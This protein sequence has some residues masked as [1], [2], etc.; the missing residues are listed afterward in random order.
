MLQ[1][2]KLLWTS[3]FRCWATSKIHFNIYISEHL[4][5][6]CLLSFF[7]LKG[8]SCSCL[9]C[10]FEFLLLS[11]IE[12]TFLL[13]LAWSRTVRH[14]DFIVSFPQCHSSTLQS[15]QISFVCVGEGYG[16]FL[17]TRTCLH[18]FCF[19]VHKDKTYHTKEKHKLYFERIFKAVSLGIFENLY[20][21]LEVKCYFSC[22]PSRTR[23]VIA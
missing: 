3:S 20:I 5:S 19:R 16:K 8:W 10:F 21:Y 1:K 14:V 4:F 13:I 22:P 15:L 17:H 11:P 6:N 7:I 23:K 2:Y 18:I 9:P 12:A